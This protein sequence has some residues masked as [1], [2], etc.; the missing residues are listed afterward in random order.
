MYVDG[1]SVSPFSH[2]TEEDQ[3]GASAEE[4]TEDH[5]GAPEREPEVRCQER[6]V[7]DLQIREPKKGTELAMCLRRE[8]L[9]K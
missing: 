5:V 6:E 2:C 9:R 7:A 4:V 1:W 3:G 8:V